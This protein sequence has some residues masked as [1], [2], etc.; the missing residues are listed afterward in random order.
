MKTND[1]PSRWHSL[2]RTVNAAARALEETPH[3]E[4]SIGQDTDVKKL[5]R[6]RQLTRR[7]S[8]RPLTWSSFV[9]NATAVEVLQE[10]IAA[11]RVDSRPLDH[12]LLYGPSGAGKTTLARLVAQSMG[13]HCVETVAS[14]LT[15]PL[16]AFRVLNR[17]NVAYEST[18]RPSTLFLDEVHRLGAVTSARSGT[19]SRG[20]DEEHL[21]GILEDFQFRH[22]LADHQVTINGHRSSIQGD[23]LYCWPFTLV[24]ATTDPGLLSAALRRR[25]IVTVEMAPYTEGEVARIIAGAA[26]RL[27]WSLDDD[28]A[29]A[30]A[31]TARSNP[32]E[33]VRLLHQARARAIATG[34]DAVTVA[35]VTEIVR[36]L[37][38]HELGLTTH[39]VA[40]LKLLKDRGKRGA[41]A[42]EIARALGIAVTTFTEL[43]EPY[44]RQLALVEVLSRRTITSRGLAYLASIGHADSSDP[45]VRAAEYGTI[46]EAQAG[47]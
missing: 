32:A 21:F 22:G 31:K 30:L 3:G 15:T 4:T 17:L 36:R 33:G 43:I 8:P 45:T 16:D 20:L 46:A 47:S 41:G 10:A 9:G 40:V 2:R 18:G 13:G 38:L 35:V 37:G 14:A 24:A 5:E 26:E 39:D 28:A 6:W 19:S 12:V 27:A 29:R 7:M 42:A 1:R 23:V 11:A 34:R 25:L 44:L